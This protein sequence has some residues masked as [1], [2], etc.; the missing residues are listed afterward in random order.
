MPRCFAI[1]IDCM[2]QKIS[3]VDRLNRRMDFKSLKMLRYLD[4]IKTA[5]NLHY[6]L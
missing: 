6:H 2:V 1:L 4:A 5:H 3:L